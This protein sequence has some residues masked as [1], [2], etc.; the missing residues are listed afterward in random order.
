MA[1]KTT[2]A[3]DDKLRRSIKKIAAWLDISQGEVVRRAIKAYEDLIFTRKHAAPEDVLARADPIELLFQ[4]ATEKVWASDPKSKAIQQ[5][6]AEGPETI[7]DFIL[8]NWD[9]GLDE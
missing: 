9:S 7:D 4:E 5:M 8:D 2:V 1:S 3:I 6:L